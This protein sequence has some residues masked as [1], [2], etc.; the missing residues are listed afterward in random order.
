MPMTKPTSEQVTFLAAGSGATQRTALDKL[1]DVVS[2]R[3]FG[4]VGDGVADDTAAIQAAIAFAQQFG[5]TVVFPISQT[6]LANIVI[7]TNN[8]QTGVTLLFES[9][10]FRNQQ[11]P[12]LL[13]FNPALPAITLGTSTATAS[14]VHIVGLTSWGRTGDQQFMLVNTATNCSFERLNI[15]NFQDFCIRITSTAANSTSFLDFSNCNFQAG[16][17]STSTILELDYGGSFNNGCMFSNCTFSL[18]TVAENAILCTSPTNLM[19]HFFSNGW[20][21][22]GPATTA[23]TAHLKIDGN[24]RLYFNNMTIDGSSTTL[25][26]EYSGDELPNAYLRGNYAIQG[27]FKSNGVLSPTQNLLE[28]LAVD[29]LVTKMTAR[30]LELLDATVTPRINQLQASS[31]AQT[32]TRSGST[33]SVASNES[34]GNVNL[35]HGSGGNI[36]ISEA[37]GG[38]T[39]VL[40]L[41]TFT[42]QGGNNTPEGAVTASVGSIFMRVNGGAGTTLYVKESGSGNT[43]WVAK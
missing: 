5:G 27:F 22:G 8:T 6:Y 33:L 23:R 24:A 26:F 2:V 18:R 13:P 1:R 30:R 31:I 36:R 14:R 7:T 28:P 10:Q 35:V 12:G 16:T 40:Q 43:G 42:I 17:A 19:V 34:G 25:S 9:G 20:I 32:I 29:P 21:E 37:S 41:S 4:A 11:Y 3:D 39:G 15:G 38:T